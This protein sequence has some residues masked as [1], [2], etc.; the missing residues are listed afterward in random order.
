MNASVQDVEGVR[1]QLS[2]I[3]G[4]EIDATTTIFPPFIPTLAALLSWVKMCLSIM[5]VPF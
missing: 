4:R 5:L 1:K 3:I 2:E